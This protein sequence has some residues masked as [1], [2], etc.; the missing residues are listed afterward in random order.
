M[1]R[2]SQKSIIITSAF[3]N[4]VSRRMSVRNFRIHEK[5]AADSPYSV[6]LDSRLKDVTLLFESGVISELSM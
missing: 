4:K 2:G 6:L 1:W 5:K 3:L